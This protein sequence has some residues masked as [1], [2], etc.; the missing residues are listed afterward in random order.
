MID[1]WRR[2]AFVWGQTDC[3]AAVCTHI[4]KKTGIDPAA[5]W[6]GTYS[7]EVGAQALYLP[8]GGVLGLFTYGMALAGFQRAEPQS[9]FPVVCDFGGVE[10]AGVYM[11]PRCAFMA[12]KGCIE[13]RAKI[14]GAWAI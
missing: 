14:L 1:Q 9:G 4:F 5:P 13:T 7:D 2:Q 3:I 12:P 8:F 11:G 10:V 6:R